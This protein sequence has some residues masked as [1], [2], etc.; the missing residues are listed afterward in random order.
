M[1]EPPKL[2][3][4]TLIGT[5]ETEYGIPISALTFLPLGADSASAA[6]RAHA[7]DGAIYFLKVRALHGFS[8]PSLL[9]PLYLHEQGVPH[10]LTPLPTIA[11]APWVLLNDFAL[12]L[13]PFVEGRM[14][15]DAGLSERNWTEL[16]ATVKQIHASQLPSDLI[17]IVPREN[18]T[19]SR[20]E[21][22]AQLQTAIESHASSDPVQ[23]ELAE[24]W[25]SRREEVRALVERADALACQLREVSS[26]LVLCHADLHTWN[27]I[28]DSREHLWLVDWDETILALKERDLMFVM[29]GIGRGLVSPKETA[30]FL[31]GYGEADIDPK[32]LTYYRYAWAVQ[33]MGAYGEQIFF[34]P[35]LGE[36]SRRDALEGFRSMFE[37]GNIVDIAFGSDSITQ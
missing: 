11:Q 17:P 18:F 28:L 1:R 4:A 25:K 7:I 23:D 34:S 26:S 3:D 2:P 14:G 9:V 22:L 10:L 5:V 32:A 6:Y 35:G 30:C 15:A 33:D 31:Q 37:P 20:R 29:G 12:S 8:P 13:F 24:F 27:I 16:G 21:V 36:A 19:P